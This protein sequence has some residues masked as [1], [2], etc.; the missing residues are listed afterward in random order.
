MYATME[1]PVRAARQLWTQITAGGSQR[2]RKISRLFFATTASA[3]R[4]FKGH[5]CSHA[6]FFSVVSSAATVAGQG[7]TNNGSNY[8]G[9][10]ND[11]QDVNSAFQGPLRTAG[12]L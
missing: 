1:V 2:V 5:S 9:S 7:D 6:Q 4:S 8:T 3:Y 11:M 12:K 10:T